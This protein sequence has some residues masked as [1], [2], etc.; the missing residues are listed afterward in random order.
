MLSPTGS[1]GQKALVP[2]EAEKMRGCLYVTSYG[3]FQ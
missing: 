1:A 2:G 3:V